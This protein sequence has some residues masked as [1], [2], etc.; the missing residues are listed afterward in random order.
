MFRLCC[1]VIGRFVKPNQRRYMSRRKTGQQRT[2]P[3]SHLPLLRAKE[4]ERLLSSGNARA[5]LGDRR[6]DGQEFDRR[7]TGIF[8]RSWNKPQLKK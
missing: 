4:E 2:E 8:F 1:F 7:D 3:P 5:L 6:E